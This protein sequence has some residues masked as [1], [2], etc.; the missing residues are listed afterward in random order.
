MLFNDTWIVSYLIRL[1]IMLNTVE[2]ANK[3]RKYKY[4]HKLL[5]IFY[6]VLVEPFSS[7]YLKY[8]IYYYVVI[9]R[10]EK[11]ELKRRGYKHIT[12]Y[13]SK[14]WRIG[15]E[16]DHAQR[17]YYVAFFNN[18]RCFVKIA[19][20]D[21]TI[22]NEIKI[23]K[24]LS[25]KNW[26]FLP[27]FLDYDLS[28][29]ESY[30]LLTVEY[31]QGLKDIDMTRE[32]FS[33]DAFCVKIIEILNA[34]YEVSLVHADIHKGNLVEDQNG[35]LYLLDYGISRFINK[36]NDVD[37]DERPG[38]YFFYD[39]NMRVYDDAFSIVQ[40]INYQLPV[41]KVNMNFYYN[42]IKSFI[43]RCCFKVNVNEM[44]LRF[45]IK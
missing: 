35:N 45:N 30:K 16:K 17:R 23:Q 24:D 40:M 37:Y 13:K 34:L 11:K 20:N 42:Q 26:K 36:T 33:F 8:M 44:Y 9:C 2:I 38:T 39:D 18:T 5:S 19:K 3:V 14:N 21:K 22:I 41:E 25:N 28:F 7:G 15:K 43:G 31:M 29:I 32:G 12:I 4:V 10:K 27:A 1:K 6:Y